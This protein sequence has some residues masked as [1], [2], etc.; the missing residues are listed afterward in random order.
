MFR[1]ILFALTLTSVPSISI[2]AT[3]TGQVVAVLD[4]DTLEVL[5]SNH[6]ERIRVNGIDCPEK[7]INTTIF[8]TP[9]LRFD[10]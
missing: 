2:A 9:A 10:P 1:A 6:P 5:H 7:W 3:F 8:P 4:G